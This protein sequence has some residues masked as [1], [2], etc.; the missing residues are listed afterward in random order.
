M[1]HSPSELTVAQVAQVV[2]PGSTLASAHQSQP[3]AE[4]PAAAALDAASR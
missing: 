2:V 1:R 3:V 4:P